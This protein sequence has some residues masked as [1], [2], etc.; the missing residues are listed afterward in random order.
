MKDMKFL[1]NDKWAVNLAHIIDINVSANYLV[2]T[3]I[4]GRE[5]KYIY[6]P[7]FALKELVEEILAFTADD[8]AHVFDCKDAMEMLTCEPRLKSMGLA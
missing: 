6:G 4:D 1:H 7:E 5:E 3:T 8:T 2:L